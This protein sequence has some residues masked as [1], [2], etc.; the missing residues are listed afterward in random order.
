MVF[1][2][3]CVYAHNHKVIKFL[4]RENTH[5]MPNS[6]YASILLHRHG[7]FP[8]RAWTRSGLLISMLEK[9]NWLHFTSP[10]TLVLFIYAKIDGFFV[11]IKSYF[12]LLGLTFSSKLSLLLKVPPRKLEP[13]NFFLLS[14]LCISI[15]LSC[16]E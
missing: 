8:E 1:E 14:L 2:K 9:L 16:I 13:L 11:E 7:E 12:K 15:N 6:I 3:Y 4:K 10:E 5:L